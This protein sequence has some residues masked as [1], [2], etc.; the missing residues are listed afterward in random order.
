VTDSDFRL[1]TA[2]VCG[3]DGELGPAEFEAAMRRQIKL[4]VQVRRLDLFLTSFFY[5]DY[6]P[7]S[8]QYLTVLRGGVCEARRDGGRCGRCGPGSL[9][10]L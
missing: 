9:A 4:A 8:R 5:Q 6:I 10:G 2:G 1:I 7:G 3:P